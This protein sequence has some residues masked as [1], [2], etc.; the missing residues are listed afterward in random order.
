M[1]L[2][3]AK[4]PLAALGGRGEGGLTPSASPAAQTDPGSL[5]GDHGA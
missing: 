4:D 5:R 3:F 1:Q 2:T